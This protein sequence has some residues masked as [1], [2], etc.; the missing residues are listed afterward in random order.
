MRRCL[1]FDERDVQL[2][3]QNHDGCV[4]PNDELHSDGGVLHKAALTFRHAIHSLNL[5]SKLFAAMNQ[6]THHHELQEESNG[7]D[8]TTTPC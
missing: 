4:V 6:P 3:F 5:E 1:F 2:W 8:D 7:D